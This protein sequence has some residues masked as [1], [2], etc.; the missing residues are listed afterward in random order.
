MTT[1]RCRSILSLRLRNIIAVIFSDDNSE[2]RV[3]SVN[4]PQFSSARARIF[5][6]LNHVR[7]VCLHVSMILIF[8]VSSPYSERRV[9]VTRAG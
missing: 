3:G 8:P 9:R 6:F 2:A 7:F 4:E 5:V 1:A